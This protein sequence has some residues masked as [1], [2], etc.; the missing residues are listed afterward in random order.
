MSVVLK[1][2]QQRRPQDN[3]TETDVCYALDK[4]R[5]LGSGYDVVKL[6]DPHSTNSAASERTYIRATPEEMNTDVFTLMRYVASK[7][8]GSSG[9]P[10]S[11]T[12]SAV[13]GGPGDRPTAT[14]LLS[15]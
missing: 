6:A 11:R 14:R 5:V 12:T 3:V 9:S 10:A 1:R 8:K 7:G 13:G 4:V 2:L 15:R